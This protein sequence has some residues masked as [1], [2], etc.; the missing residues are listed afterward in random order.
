MNAELKE[1]VEREW[2]SLLEKGDRTSPTEYPEIC[3]ITREELAEAMLAA[4]ESAL[5]NTSEAAPVKDGE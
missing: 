5:A 2:R 1:A 3:L 4:L